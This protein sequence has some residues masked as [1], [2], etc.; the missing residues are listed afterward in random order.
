M[1]NYINNK[2]SKMEDKGTEKAAK[3]YCPM[4]VAEKRLEYI[5]L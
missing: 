5:Y 2:I 1:E 3:G 4:S